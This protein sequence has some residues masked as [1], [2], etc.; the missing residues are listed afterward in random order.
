MLCSW[1]GLMLAGCGCGIPEVHPISTEERCSRELGQAY[2][3]F[4]TKKKRGPQS[5]KE[6]NIKGQ[7]YPM[8]VEM[9]KEGNLIVHWAKSCLTG[10]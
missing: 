7:Q 6:L 4:A 3:N 5:L 1:L 10:W 8:A 9:I 2:L